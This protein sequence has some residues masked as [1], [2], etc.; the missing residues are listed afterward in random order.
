M[1]E[2]TEELVQRYQSISLDSSVY[3]KYAG[4]ALEE[5]FL[6]VGYDLAH[7][8]SQIGE[9][10]KYVAQYRHIGQS[11]SIII[12]DEQGTIISDRAGHEGENISIFGN[13]EDR[14]L[15]EGQRFTADINGEASY[16]M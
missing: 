4:V 8:Q 9:Q 10:V 14:T 3:R 5:S 2:G 12:C 11:G 7:L 13:G 16:G 6:Q 1:L 15:V